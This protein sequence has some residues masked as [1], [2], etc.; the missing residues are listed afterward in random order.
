[1]ISRFAPVAL[2]LVLL[3]AGCTQAN[4]A[5]IEPF[6]L[7]DMP[8]DAAKCGFAAKCDAYMSTTAI[9]VGLATALTIGVELHNQATDNT[10]ADTGGVNTHDATVRSIEISYSGAAISGR[11]VP[12]VAPVPAGGTTV[13]PFVLL[14]AASVGTTYVGA[15]SIIASVKFKGIYG[16]G[17]EFETGAL[18]IPVKVCGG[19]GCSPSLAPSCPAGKTAGAVCPPNGTGGLAGGQF[20]QSVS[21]Q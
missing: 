14:P 13:L 10:N 12:V 18:E 15:E 21:C 11:T 17:S 16:D 4:F 20:P 19:S 3:A 2:A 5:S 8:A 9:N 1:M 6:G 7:C